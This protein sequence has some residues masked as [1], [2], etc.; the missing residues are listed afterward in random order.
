MANPRVRPHLQFLPEDAGQKLDQAWQARRWLHEMQHEVLTP[1][2]RLASNS[3]QE[4][5]LYVFEPTLLK[6]WAGLNA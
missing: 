4:Q 2:V 3:P 5:D 1:M 6:K